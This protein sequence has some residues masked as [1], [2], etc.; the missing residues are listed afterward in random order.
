MAGADGTELAAARASLRARTRADEARAAAALL[1]AYPLDGPARRRVEARAA[2]FVNGARAARRRFG[3]VDDFLLEYGLDTGE[4]VALMCLAE[5]LLRVPDAGTADRLIADKLAGVDWERH[6]GHSDSLFVNASTWALLLTGEVVAAEAAV[7]ER[8]ASLL[9]RL[10]ARLGEP[11]V[12]AAVIQAMRVLGGQFVMGRSIAEGLERAAAEA[13]ET[14]ARHSFDMLGEAARTQADADRYLGAYERAIAAIAR[15]EGAGDPVA[16]PG[17]S[18][19]LSALDPRFEWVQRGRAVPAVAGHLAGLA[20]ACKAAGIGLTVDA[21]EAER[22]EPMLDVVAAVAADRALAGWD[23]FGLAVQAYQKRAPDVIGWLAALSRATGRRLTVRLV[24]GAYWDSEIK[25]A[26]ERGLDGYPVFTRKAATDVSW[27]VCAGQLLAD[28]RAFYPQFATHNAHSVAAVLELA[29]ARRDW[30]FQRLHGMGEPLYHQLAGDEAPAVR[31]YAPV[32]SHEDLLPYLV[33]RLLE[34]GA[35]ASFVHRLRDDSLPV[36][37]VVAD[38]AARLAATGPSPHPKIVL[39]R[40]LYGTERVNSAGLDLADPVQ[41]DALLA[42]MDAAVTGDWRA[43]PLIDGAARDGEAKAMLDPS[44]RRRRVGAVVPAGARDVTDA[45]GAAAAAFDAWEATPARERAAILDR[46]AAAVE[47][48]HARL[49]AMI[50]REGGRTVADALSEVR[51]TVDFCRY[52]AARARADFAAPLPLP[53]PTGEANTLA[54]RGRGV[55]ACIAPWNFPLSIFTGQVVAA[56]A[57]GN[58]VVAKPAGQTPLVAAAVVGLLHEAGVPGGALALL[59]GGVGAALV[60]DSRIAGVAV[61]GSTATA[62][63]IDRTL[64]AKD[65]PIAPLIAE[66][67]GLNAMLVDATALPEQVVDDTIASAFR[68]A[69]QR[70]SALR[71]L[72]LQEEIADRIEAMLAGAMAALVVGDPMDL[73]TDVGPLIDAAARDA[74]AAH[75]ATLAG[76]GRLIG[77]APLDPAL[78]ARGAFFAPSAWVLRPEDL[79]DREV[80]GPILHIARWPAGAL[81]ATID[82]INAPGYGLTLGVHSRIDAVHRRVAARARAGNIYVNRSIIGAV[83]GTQPFGGE[84]LSGTGPKAGGPRYLHR[85]AVERTLAVNTAAAGGNAALVALEE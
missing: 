5:A 25:R 49:A 34:N 64:A 32:G 35:N 39:P 10:V 51:E 60:A 61:T 6:L 73:A 9:S 74:L 66:T 38:P 50:V 40:D 17:L 22:L 63:A 1:A 71:V 30:E 20:R 2:G 68:S 41:A 8:P 29:G 52:Y 84:G 46:A 37:S 12:R 77:R 3:G 81:D 15:A 27:L 21:E 43:A 69:G 42:A 14:G 44:D 65:G 62:R 70:C 36:A 11:V 83:V 54:L 48:A 78:A 7:P 59:P 18:V 53:G 55:F 26:Q 24:K 28:P 79:P 4:G 33:R 23:G 19:K 57:A 67:G 80:F 72:W 56:L 13:H 31:V 76:K 85:F 45:V 82:R 58:T 47:A 16:G 75:E